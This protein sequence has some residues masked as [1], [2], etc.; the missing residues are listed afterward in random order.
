MQVF[1]HLMIYGKG[2]NLIT[3]TEKEYKELSP[4]KKQITP[5]VKRRQMIYSNPE[6][7]HVDEKWITEGINFIISDKEGESN[8]DK[9]NN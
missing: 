8:E 7:P 3:I 6:N 9:T 4:D 5:L 1:S 2:G